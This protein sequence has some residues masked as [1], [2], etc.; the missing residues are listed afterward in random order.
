MEDNKTY[1]NI[2]IARCT[3]GDPES[4]ALPNNRMAKEKVSSMIARCTPDEVPDGFCS[5]VTALGATKFISKVSFYRNLNHILYQAFLIS[6]LI[7]SSIN[8]PQFGSMLGS[9]S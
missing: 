8:M 1:L 4:P 9:S 6:K 3:L 5:K 2:M 7:T